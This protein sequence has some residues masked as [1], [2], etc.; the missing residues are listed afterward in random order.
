MG[1][2]ALLCY[3]VS[4]W[5]RKDPLFQAFLLCVSFLSDMTLYARRYQRNEVQTD[6]QTDIVP[7][8]QRSSRQRVTRQWLIVFCVG[9]WNLSVRRK[10]WPQTSWKKGWEK[11]TVVLMLTNVLLNDNWY[12]IADVIFK[13]ENMPR[14]VIMLRRY[15]R[16]CAFESVCLTSVC[17]VHRA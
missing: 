4:E 8:K 6:R 1:T 13:V 3:R 7:Y 5:T 14:T 15:K 11:Y 17:R 12:E 16:W 10:T 9:K 2:W